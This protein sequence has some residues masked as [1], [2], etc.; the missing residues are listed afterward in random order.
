MSEWDRLAKALHRATGDEGDIRLNADD[1]R[2]MAQI[3]EDVHPV[4]VV[5]IGTFRGKSARV[6]KYL[7]A[8]KV[9]TIDKEPVD[10][11]ESWIEVLKGDSG[12]IP[13]G[14]AVDL[15]WVDG[16]HRYDG[17]MRDLQHWMPWARKMICG[18]DYHEKESELVKAVNDF[19]GG[20]IGVDGVIWKFD[21][22]PRSI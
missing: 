22:R 17:V 10:L 16:D 19:F 21:K 7:G 5:D 14:K 15:V 11:E 20:T 2:V 4:E 8:E 1:I 18:H 12:S 9:Y 3:F 13:W 6:W